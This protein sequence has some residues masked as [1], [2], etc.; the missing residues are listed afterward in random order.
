MT[1]KT[2][3]FDAIERNHY[4]GNTFYHKLGSCNARYF[5]INSET[6]KEWIVLQSYS[7]YVAMYSPATAT[8]YVRRYYSATTYQHIYKFAREMKAMRITWLYQKSDNIIETPISQYAIAVKLNSKQWE[9][10]E[11]LDYRDYIEKI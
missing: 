10:Q 2:E 8:V 4:L 11:R 5:S 3:L 6:G 7:S 9:T 1:T